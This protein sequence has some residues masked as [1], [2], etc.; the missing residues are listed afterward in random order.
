MNTLYTPDLSTPVSRPLYMTSSEAK[1]LDI[2]LGVTVF[3]HRSA[4]CTTDWHPLL[5]VGS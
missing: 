2:T 1:A 5:T 4:T 3:N